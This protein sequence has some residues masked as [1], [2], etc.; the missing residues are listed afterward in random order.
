LTAAN[1]TRTAPSFF[2]FRQMN[3]AFV[4]REMQPLDCAQNDCR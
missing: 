4:V 2:F 3:E 1:A